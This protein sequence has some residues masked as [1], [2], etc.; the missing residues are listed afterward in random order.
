RQALQSQQYVREARSA[1]LPT[2]YLSLT[3][4]DSDPGGRITAG[5]LTNPTVFPRAAARGT[6]SPLVTD[7][8]RTTTLVSSSKFQEK[9]EDQNAA[10]T[11]ADIILAVDQAFY[12]SFE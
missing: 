5:G 8:G 12:N 9:A 1:L 7:F 6:G 4:V 11:T 2:A 10:A 3:A